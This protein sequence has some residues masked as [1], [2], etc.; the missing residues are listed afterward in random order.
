M[1]TEKIFDAVVHHLP[2]QAIVDLKGEI[3]SF[4]EE[5]LNT[6]FTDAEA[7]AEKGRIQAIVL[8]FSE[9]TYINSTGIALIV[10]LMSRARKAGRKLVVYGLSD[11]YVEI[12]HI[13][14]LSDFL[15]IFPDR[16]SALAS[17]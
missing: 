7:W 11:H 3:N 16:E 2:G 8:N 14:R 13:T 17:V 10:G 6:A 5:G 1:T 15:S 4:A 9:V 12:F